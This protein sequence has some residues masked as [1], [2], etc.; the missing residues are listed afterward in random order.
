MKIARKCVDCGKQFE[1]P[2]SGIIRCDECE[3][4]AHV[5]SMALPERQPLGY[6]DYLEVTRLSV[7]RRPYLKDATDKHIR[8]LAEQEELRARW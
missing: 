1:P 3:H 5:R 8:E 2:Y 4:A 6:L 7:G